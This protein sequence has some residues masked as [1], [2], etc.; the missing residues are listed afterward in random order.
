MVYLDKTKLLIDSG[1][2]NLA[3]AST[4]LD[5][6][7]TWFNASKSSTLNIDD[8][9]IALKYQQGSWSGLIANDFFDLVDTRS[10][11][12]SKKPPRLYGQ[13]AL[14]DEAKDFFLGTTDSMSWNGIMGLA[15]ANIAVQPKNLA[16]ISYVW[17]H[18]LFSQ[19]IAIPPPT[20]STPYLMPSTHSILDDVLKQYELNDQFSVLLCGTSKLVTSNTF[21]ASMKQDGVLT[22]GG[23][24]KSFKADSKPFF[25][26]PI[27]YAWYY[28]VILTDFR[29]NGKKV[30]EDCKELNFDKTI[31]DTGT[32]N[33]RLPFRVFRKF[34]RLVRAHV[35]RSGKRGRA[36]GRDFWRSKSLLCQDPTSPLGGP[37][38]SP[39]DMFPQLTFDFVLAGN[40]SLMKSISTTLSPEQY[41]RYI[42]R[43][44][45]KGV[46]KDCFVFGVQPSTLGTILG[47]VFIEGF[48]TLF[49]R[50][51]MKVSRPLLLLASSD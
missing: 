48:Y 47:S 49:D 22:I 25:Y 21:S 50:Q 38:G 37:L 26:T 20:T 7:S 17:I 46:D 29:V 32:T 9:R 44:K 12:A 33:I 34:V 19:N 8:D 24:K 6:V 16:G 18:Y 23:I 10:L 45:S 5:G 4:S 39:Y 43:V 15:F 30:I 27:R 2:A 41:I 13:I 28:E 1:S 31:L 14:I 36:I 11:P 42:G 35:R 3:V 51:N 40:A